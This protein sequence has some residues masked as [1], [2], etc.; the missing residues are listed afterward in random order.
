MK[1]DF[2]AIESLRFPLV[3]LVVLIHVNPQVVPLCESGVSIFSS[4]GL[5]IVIATFLSHVISHM[6]VPCFFVISGYL[7]FIHLSDWDWKG[8]SEKLRRRFCSLLIPYLIW[9]IMPF[10][11]I[12]ILK[13]GAFILKGKP[14]TS[15]INYVSE[16]G[17]HVFWDLYSVDCDKTNWFGF[18]RG[19]IS[20][21]NP[22][23]WYIKY[24]IMVCLLAPI[25]YWLVL[26]FRIWAVVIF[27]M[28]YLLKAWPWLQCITAIFYFSVGAY[29][30]IC[31]KEMMATFNK[32]LR[33][34]IPV[35]L[36]IMAADVYFDGQYTDV[37]YYFTHY[38]FVILGV[39]VT[40]GLSYE[41]SHKPLGHVFSRLAK[42]SFFI[43]AA[44]AANVMQPIREFLK[45]YL[46]Y[47]TLAGLIPYYI[48]VAGLTILV[49]ITL[50][51]LL[52]GFCPRMLSVLTGG[53]S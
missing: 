1:E 36:L 27:G 10:L 5:Y 37:G 12:F 52:N 7:F 45:G 26:K 47:D 35:A 20:P 3:V 28:L 6:A 38:I 17:W 25:I 13:L 30:S 43:Y 8:Y 23:M 15:M 11:Y 21:Y 19:W 16:R 4:E 44:H 33:Y 49:C 39:T 48:L 22:P 29:F 42:Y 18:T 50:F 51:I 32:R 2:K 34:T 41:I 24:L 9:N 46:P 31:E 14:L 40:L 53:R